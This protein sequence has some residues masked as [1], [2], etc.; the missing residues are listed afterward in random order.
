MPYVLVYASD[1]ICQPKYGSAALAGKWKPAYRAICGH[2]IL[3]FAVDLSQFAADADPF[4]AGARRRATLE[5][6][7]DQI[8]RIA[9]ID[10]AIAIGIA[11][12]NLIWPRR[13]PAFEYKGDQIDGIAD[14][15]LR[16]KIAIAGY[17]I[18]I[19]A[20]GDNKRKIEKSFK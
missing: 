18:A 19:E 7:T 17:A 16:I 15:R 5:N 4:L 6:P 8:D 14:I 2:Y 20:A 11:A 3:T 10:L 9:D 13:R 1:E 12:A